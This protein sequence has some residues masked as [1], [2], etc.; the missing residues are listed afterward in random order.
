MATFDS[1]KN[2]AYSSVIVPPVDINGTSLTITSGTG[3]KFPATP[4]NAVIW[5]LAL[6][7][8]NDNAEIVRVTNITG[9][10]L[11]ITRAQESTTAQPITAGYQIAASITAKM[12]T[13]IE[14]AINA[15]PN[16]W[17]L[18]GNDIYRNSSLGLNTIPS[19]KLHVLG[20]TEQL[21]LSYN[22]TRSASFTVNSDG[23][24]TIVA[25]GTG[26]NI[27][28]YPTSTGYVKIGN[29]LQLTTN[30]SSSFFDGTRIVSTLNSLT[31]SATTASARINF[32]NVAAPTT[33][34]IG[35][36]IDP[37]NR[38][39]ELAS[40]TK[41]GWSG[42]TQAGNVKDVGL[43]RNA[44]GVIEVNSGTVGD[45]RDI[46]LRTLTATTSF[47]IGTGNAL[48]T[49]SGTTSGLYVTDYL[50]N[51]GTI[52]AQTFRE[53]HSY[54]QLG[55]YGIG[56]AGT[57]ASNQIIGWTST[58]VYNLNDTRDVGLFRNAANVLE[59][60]TGTAGS[61]ADLKVRAVD[62]TGRVTSTLTTEQLRIGYDATRY[63]S[64]TVNSTGGLTLAV[65]QANQTLTINAGVNGTV[66]SSAR[67]D[68]GSVLTCAGINALT[69]SALRLGNAGSIFWFSG[70]TWAS[71]VADLGLK[72]N[73]ANVL[74]I[75][76]GTLGQYADLNLRALTGT[77]RLSTTLVTEQLRL[78]YDINNY[79]SFTVG[80]DGTLDISASGNIVN[81]AG[82]MAT[83]SIYTSSISFDSLS[84]NSAPNPYLQLETLDNYFQINGSLHISNGTNPKVTINA[85]NGYIGINT[86]SPRGYF[87][88][89]S[90]NV[91]TVGDV[92]S[93]S[94]E[95]TEG[96]AWVG[97]S[98]DHFFHII[99][100]AYKDDVLGRVYSVNGYSID[101]SIGAGTF[102]GLNY[103]FSFDWP[104]VPDA[105]GYRVVIMRA[106]PDGIFSAEAEYY[107][108]TLNNYA[109]LGYDDYS[110][111][112]YSSQYYLYE[113]PVVLTPTSLSSG[114]NLYVASTGDLYTANKVGIGIENPTYFL[115]VSGEVKFGNRIHFGTGN[116]F[117]SNN[118]E[119][120]VLQSG[121]N[122]CAL[123]LQGTTGTMTA[124][125]GGRP[126]TDARPGTFIGSNGSNVPVRS[127]DA[128]T[129]NLNRII[130]SALSLKSGVGDLAPAAN[131]GLAFSEN[132]NVSFGTSTGTK[133]GIAT[134]Q[135]L[136]F[137][138]ATPIIQPT[139]SVAAST[140]VANSGTAVNDASTFDGY[141]M[142]QVVKALRN[143]GLLA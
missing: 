24:L 75:N 14:E 16:Y 5:P 1:H 69:S 133:I 73:T 55:Y 48:Q 62:T 26:Q 135:K 110:Y 109:R 2:F 60:N 88:I 81:I 137:W 50:G 6:L 120:L 114:P 46:T 22:A 28:F 77:G 67:F 9:D 39:I 100:Y 34:Q 32:S 105:T 132:L 4:F 92:T 12:I 91:I 117:F 129:G 131:V 10:V 142:K 36:S 15:I 140:F 119:S 102:N 127:E 44:A 72:R 65:A 84:S 68:I 95:F 125:F 136:S 138:N 49:L 8:T 53:S 83:S 7:P 89:T 115:E 43:Y 38:V 79:T 106:D 31:I 71:G 101:T 25:G 108:D 111:E 123:Q 104:S 113:Y 116:F 33:A 126:S 112:S 19:A 61:F 56:L 18:N 124:Y 63:V 66:A 85:N 35:V 121:S 87:D 45:F 17:T 3:V 122:S 70:G 42:D 58:G 40:N 86:A 98:G 97:D 20:T 78:A 128:T 21:R 143:V 90:D 47:K 96:G 94:E 23:E 76:N 11:T 52:S 130:C 64:F 82:G 54:I 107:F 37:T 59:I 51:S 93:H 103:S 29:Y 99:I 74:E 30:P 41:L 139:T 118:N 141:T 80:A 134:N 57:A 27:V 13:D